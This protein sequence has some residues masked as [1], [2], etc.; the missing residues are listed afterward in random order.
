MATTAPTTPGP[1]RAQVRAHPLIAFF[2]LAYALSWT[3]WTPYVL[4]E[5]G[6]GLLSFRFPTI[7]GTGQL[8]GMG[9]G[10]YLGPLTS[11]FLVTALVDGRPGLRVWRDRLLRWRVGRR[12]YAFALLGV[13][14]LVLAGFLIV[15]G[16]RVHAPSVTAVLLVVP[17]LVIQVL[18][19]GLAEEPGW[20]DFALPRIQQR[21]GPLPGTLMLGVL[22]GGWH[23]PL[24][25]TEWARVEPTPTRVLAFLAGSVAFSVVITWAFNRTGESLPIPLLMHASNNNIV[26]VLSHDLFPT[27]HSG[28]GVSPGSIGIG[29]LAVILVVATRGRLGYQPQQPHPRLAGP[30][31]S[32]ADATAGG[33]RG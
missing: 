8:L 27:V 10:A 23:L 21:L 6:L 26:S 1:V 7:L 24:F 31:F 29:A 32:S 22:W 25:L 18:T 30:R 5:N 14:L 12:W 15:S 17:G 20:R 11:A 3:A 2:V 9:P 33:L 13:P 4:S 16:A 19:T 28:A